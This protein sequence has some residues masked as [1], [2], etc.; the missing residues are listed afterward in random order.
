MIE[1]DPE[2]L[3]KKADLAYR[4]ESYLQ[5]MEIYVQAAYHSILAETPSPT[6][7]EAVEKTIRC[8]RKISPEYPD[9][10]TD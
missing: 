1:N 6:I 8:Y 10:E 9:N 3:I 5:A 4:N 7:S 2:L